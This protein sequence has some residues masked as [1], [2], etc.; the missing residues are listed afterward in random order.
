MS[1]SKEDNVYGFQKLG[2]NNYVVWSPKMRF[3]L[4]TKDLVKAIEGNDA[5]GPVVKKALATIGMHVE[6][7][8]LPIIT[9]SETAMEA[10]EALAKEH[11][12]SVSASR[13]QLR[14]ALNSLR[15]ERAESLAEYFC[16]AKR[17]RDD[18]IGIGDQVDED[19]VAMAI[20][21]G[22]P[23][24]Y[25]TVVAI[26]RFGNNKL[27]LDTCLVNLLSVEKEIERKEEE[28]TAVALYAGGNFKGKKFH[29]K[30]WLAGNGKDERECY[31]C[32]EKGHL[33][34][35]CPKLKAERKTKDARASVAFVHAF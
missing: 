30:T 2:R 5:S 20:L 11:T 28:E 23:K 13:L 26:M 21:A 9:A 8:Y 24:Q 19:Q 7:Y 22:L 32:G 3:Y 17:I 27:V 16:R 12:E 4:T 25:D 29:K 10:W 6:D 14:R 1:N 18:L 35:S 34:N 15:Q 33:R 31:H